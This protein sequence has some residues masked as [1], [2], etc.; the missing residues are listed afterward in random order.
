MTVAPTAVHRVRAAGQASR[1]AWRRSDALL[2]TAVVVLGL[3][4]LTGSA[5]LR[6]PGR[7]L[8]LTAGA[9]LIMVLAVLPSSSAA[10]AVTSL[11]VEPGG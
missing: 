7:D 4:A 10:A 5:R 9:C 1:G 3:R 11:N 2:R 8:A 6:L